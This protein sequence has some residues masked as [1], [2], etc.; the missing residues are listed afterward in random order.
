MVQEFLEALFGGYVPPGFI[1]I[2]LLEDGVKP[3][4]LLDRRWWRDIPAL[5]ADMPRLNRVAEK[6]RA[7]VFFGVLPRRIHGKGTADTIAA[8]SVAWADLDF[9]DYAGGED[10]ARDRLAAI[11]IKP[12]CVVN[13]GRGLHA[14]WFLTEPEPP[15]VC[16]T[17]GKR[18]QAALGSDNVADAPRILRLPLTKH[19]K[20][21][22]NPRDVVIETLD[23]AHR[24]NPSD[25][26]D[27]LPE[28][29]AVTAA[30][31]APEVEIEQELP[32]VVA[33]LLSQHKRLRSLFDGTG[34]PL[35]K[36]DGTR[37]DQS[38][39][40][41]DFSVCLSLIKKGVTDPNA[42]ATALACRPGTKP[43]SMDYLARTV[44]KALEV[45]GVGDDDG[46]GGGGGGD[47][48]QEIDFAPERVRIFD[49]DP[50]I[51]EITIGG[52]AMRLTTGQLILLPNFKARF[53][54]AFARIPA[55][56]QGRGAQQRWEQ[57][58]NDWLKG[59]ERVE[60]PPEASSSG[61]MVEE[62]TMAVGDLSLGENWKDLD[63]PCYLVVGDVMVFKTK[64]VMR[65][66]RADYRTEIRPHVLCSMLRDLGYDNQVMRVDG[67]SVRVWV[68]EGGTPIKAPDEGNDAVTL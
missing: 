4:R 65:I 30:S 51:Y 1:E 22:A 14:Y 3:P 68:S 20:D 17:L 57:V 15:E 25:F 61:A 8:G 46:P 42:L 40:G 26:D 45:A 18:L 55:L 67:A 47:P 66:L 56:P 49:S 41:Y 29:E 54:D 21:P 24:C 59:A 62:V 10:E 48:H 44:A 43:R 28:V 38:E 27:F 64:A 12:S 50:K 33:A 5:V 36:P 34:K 7:G 19:R 63:R 37:C 6:Q 23:A 32:P 58:V 31:P 16:C 52:Q 13:S 39:S 9:R 35:L 60:V 53:T 2:R 11:P